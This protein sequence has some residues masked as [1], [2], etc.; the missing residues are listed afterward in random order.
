MLKKVL[1]SATKLALVTTLS[2]SCSVFAAQSTLP[3]QE[4]VYA[5][6]D[7]VGTWQ[8]SKFDPKS[9]EFKGYAELPHMADNSGDSHPQ[10]WVYAAFYAGMTRWAELAQQQEKTDYYSNLK[11][12]A[13]QSRYSFGPRIYNADDYAIGQFYLDLYAKYQ[14]PAMLSSLRAIF[15]VVLNSPS[16]N[17][18][19][20]ERISSESMQTGKKIVDEYAGRHFMHVPCKM[21]WCWADAL[22]M[23]PPVWFGLAKAT[24]DQRYAEFAD[25]EFWATV[26]LLW[27]D[28]DQLFFRDS[29][30]FD[31]RE[32]NGEKVIWA[33]GVGWVA[34]GLARILEVLPADH[35][36]R[37]QY[38]DI[39]KKLMTR[40]AGAQQSDGFWRPS[41]LAPESQPYKES[42]GTA[43][44]AYAFIAGI[45]QGVLEEEQFLPVANKAWLALESVIQPDGKM[46][47]VQQIAAK[48]FAVSKDDTQLYAVGAFFLAGTEYHKYLGSLASAKKSK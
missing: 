30:F 40:L 6:M 25:K 2:L 41:V 13:E 8:W 4:S 43:L 27:D 36:K 31:K 34:A 18:L 9:A 21:R 32:K 44:I 26:D 5:V 38:E 7:K 33:R 22:F 48:P 19:Q 12:I 11:A 14:D 42:S 1:N 24:G 46:G 37:P 15:D 20:Y 16:T 23:G 10:G 47:W 45:N 3:T 29:R 39:F 17:S 28:K 35:A